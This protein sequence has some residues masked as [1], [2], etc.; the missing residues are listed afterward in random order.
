MTTDMSAKVVFV[1]AL[2]VDTI[3]VV[4]D[5]PVPDS[6]RLARD[7]V[8]AGGG[9]AATA[10]VTAA[11]LGV[12]AA[13]VGDVGDDE[14]GEQI[15]AALAAEGLDVSGVRTV[16]GARSGASVVVVDAGR[17]TRAIAARPGPVP[18]ISGVAGALIA[19]AAWVHVDHHGWRPVHAYLAGLPAGSRPQLS[20]DG[21][22]PIDGFTPAGADLYVPTAEALVHRYGRAPVEELLARALEEGAVRVVATRGARGALAATRDG[23]LH[24]ARGHATEVVSTL[25]AGDV[26]HGALVAAIAG[27]APLAEALPYANVAAALSC[28][29]VDGR[30]A[31]PMDPEIRAVLRADQ[32]RESVPA[33]ETR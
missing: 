11:R 9:P 20:V 14:D 2:T 1:G 3:A 24:A 12:R 6:R 8:R 33:E 18:V 10:A 25:G 5:F 16:P 17:G 21:G 4:D 22:N 19:R 15:V 28:R 13:V 29:A 31:I 26:L 23:G 27:G 32:A 7:I 30:S